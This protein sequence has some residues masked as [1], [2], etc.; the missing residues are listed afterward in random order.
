[1]NLLTRKLKKAQQRLTHLFKNSAF[2]MQG[3]MDIHPS[4]RWYN[5]PFVEQT[6]G[7]FPSEGVESLR[8]IE[9]LEPWDN[10]RRDMIALLLRT[11]CEHEIPGDFAEL[12][13]YKGY[14]ARLIHHYAPERILH[15]FDTFDGFPEKSMDADKE[16]VNNPISKK[17]FTDT[18]VEKVKSVV[19]SRNGNV[20]YYKGYFPESIPETFKKNTFPFVHLDADLYLPVKD[21]LQFFYERMNKGGFILIHDYNAWIG[22]RKAVDE[23]F[24][25]KPE[26]PIPMPDKS[27]SALIQ[28]Q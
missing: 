6:A 11:I 21:G 4:S 1:M 24:K 26:I 12:G 19:D 13:T 5:L 8:S 28:I 10:T 22:A 3:Q 27:G 25:S 18:S 14:T 16:L 23:F 7:F 9:S 17:L 20:F 15:I 2:F